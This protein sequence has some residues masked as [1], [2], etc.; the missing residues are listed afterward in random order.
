MNKSFVWLVLFYFTTIYAQSSPTCIFAGNGYNFDLTNL[1]AQGPFTYN[2]YYNYIYQLCSPLPMNNICANSAGT[3]S[4]LGCYV[5]STNRKLSTLIGTGYTTVQSCYQAAA[6][7]SYSYFGLEAPP[8]NGVGECYGSNSYQYTA[9]S[10]GCVNGL[11]GPWAI[12]LYQIIQ[13]PL[14]NNAIMYQT[15]P[16]PCIAT[17]S[18]NYQSFNINNGQLS[19]NYTNGTINSGYN[20]YYNTN[21]TLLCNPSIIGNSIGVTINSY[22]HG[23]SI[24][25]LTLY[26]KSFCPTNLPLPQPNCTFVYAGYKYDLTDFNAQGPFIANDSMGN[27]YYYQL[28]SVVPSFAPNNTL[29]PSTSGCGLVQNLGAA[30][31]QY[32]NNSK[33]YINI[34]LAYQQQFQLVDI[35]VP[36]AGVSITYSN[37]QGQ[38]SSYFSILNLICSLV[39][40]TTMPIVGSVTHAYGPGYIF[41]LYHS[42]FCPIN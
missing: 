34:G 16:L 2:S 35:T 20:N 37:G 14:I 10:T 5:D 27:Q 1:N 24:Y 18:A 31:C 29:M 40:N 28:C 38:G 21:Y 41:N 30:V 7:K 8:P 25:G 17:G 15:Y 19:L 3:Y 22:A 12:S 9:N 13:Y 23:D 36:Y 32:Y 4:Y 33:S 39:V 42:T 11:G 26:H 6:S